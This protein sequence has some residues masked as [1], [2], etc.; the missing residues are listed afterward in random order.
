MSIREAVRSAPAYHITAQPAA[1]K[2]NQNDAAW[3]LP[4]HLRP[5][6][7]AAQAGLELNRYP[8][9]QAFGLRAQLAG[10]HDWPEDGIV[11][12]GG[13]NILIQSLV[14]AAGIGQRVVTVTPTFSVY[15]LQAQLLGAQLTEVPLLPGFGLPVEQ[16]LD[17]LTAGPGVLFIANPAAPTGNLHPPDGITALV[18]SGREHGWTVVLDQAYHQFAPSAAQAFPA[19]PHVVLLR[20]F[21]KALG[22]AGVRVGYALTSPET[23]R[24]LQK[25]VLPF[26]VSAWQQATAGVLLA[27][28]RFVADGVA[29][30][31]SERERVHA[32]LQR[33]SVTVWPSAANFLLFRV[34]DAAA[35]H[36][37]LLDGGVLVRRQDHLPDLAG[38]LRV[39]IGLPAENDLFLGVL[40]GV[41]AETHEVAP[42]AASSLEES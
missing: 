12:A 3:P 27:E 6:I 24:N 20:T 7:A 21:S 25:A 30:V 2:L 28:R 39:S 8:D 19:E 9:V 14:I 35:V 34:A 33:L 22:L 23:A 32:A 18:A 38:C 5:R 11:V 42:A 1:V 31:C 40:Q 17:T 26:S 36:A 37:G 29:L 16:L 13:S 10:H 4:R 41:L 15:S